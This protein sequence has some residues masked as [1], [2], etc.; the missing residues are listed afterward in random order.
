MFRGINVI[1][2][3][4]VAL[5]ATSAAAEDY[6]DAANNFRL[7][8][9]DGWTSEKPADPYIKLMMLS[10]RAQET[11]GQCSVITTLMPETK[12]LSQADIDAAADKE[13]DESFWLKG[14][15]VAKE[16][17]DASIESHGARMV[18]GHKAFFVLAKVTGNVAHAGPATA[19]M[20]QMLEAIPGQLFVVTCAAWEASYAKEEADFDIVLNSFAPIGDAPVAM[21]ESIGV[22]SLTMY[23]LPR[24]GGVSRVVTQ[25]AANLAVFG[26]H[27]TTASLSTA[28]S[29]AWEVCDGINFGGR[30]ETVTAALPTG[31]AGKGFAIVSARHVNAILPTQPGQTNYIDSSAQGVESMLGR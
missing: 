14:L 30:C 17:I 2:A 28:G 23:S 25:D 21:F 7:T 5:S 9:P 19:K 24:F 11:H 4:A 20:Q 26:W 8:V 29:G 12:G 6:S 10:P 31:P 3:G 16:V 13:I 22:T 15:K 27:G 18:N 1:V